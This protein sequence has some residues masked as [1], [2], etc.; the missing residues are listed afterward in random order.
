[1]GNN[2]DKKGTPSYATYSCPSRREMTRKHERY[3]IFF[4]GC[5]KFIGVI[6]IT[7]FFK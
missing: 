3:W 7:T 1:M 4:T 5:K 6:G 2:E